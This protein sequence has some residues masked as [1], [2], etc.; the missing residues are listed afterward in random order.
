MSSVT[1]MQ[2]YITFKGLKKSEF[3][4]TVGLANGYLDKVKE[5]GSDKVES[6]ITKY[7]DINLEWLITGKGPMIKENAPP[8][9]SDADNLKLRDE[10]IELQKE[11]IRLQKEIAELNRPKSRQH[12]AAR[13]VSGKLST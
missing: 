6:I 2:A 1:R 10:I 5:L 8:K 13:P 11:I 7:S 12:P 4:R 9:W 3:Y